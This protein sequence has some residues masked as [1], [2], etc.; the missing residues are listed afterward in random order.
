[1]ATLLNKVSLGAT[2]LIADL[3][4]GNGYK[5]TLVRPHESEV[6]RGKISVESPVG[7]SLIGKV[8]GD[9]VTVKVPGGIRKFEVLEITYE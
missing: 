6:G 2:V 3:S 1:M 9:L 4:N 8:A 7:R 5:Y